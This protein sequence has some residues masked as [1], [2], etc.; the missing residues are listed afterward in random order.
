MEGV[1]ELGNVV[2]QHIASLQSELRALRK[3]AAVTAEEPAGSSTGTET[4][5]DKPFK[6]TLMDRFTKDMVVIQS[7]SKTKA[8]CEL[9]LPSMVAL[10]SKTSSQSFFL[11]L[12]KVI[13]NLRDSIRG[14]IK[15]YKQTGMP[16]N[17]KILS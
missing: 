10:T 5:A 4:D 1:R 3:D 7:N 8:T 14:A 6:G 2:C 11:R 15:K 9:Q 13:I 17:F 16:K 12:L